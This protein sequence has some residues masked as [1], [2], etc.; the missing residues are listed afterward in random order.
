MVMKI[1]KIII[2]EV[3]S[4]LNHP[5]VYKIP[6]VFLFIFKGTNSRSHNF[7]NNYD[8]SGIDLCT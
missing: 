4:S 8:M 1:K 5:G 7:L 3:I 2:V 6:R